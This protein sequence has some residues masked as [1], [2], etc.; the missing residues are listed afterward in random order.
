MH[1]GSQTCG[2]ANTADFSISN[3]LKAVKRTRITSVMDKQHFHRRGDGK[4]RIWESGNPLPLNPV[5][6]HPFRNFG[7][8]IL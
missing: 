5:L 3:P 7:T 4:D 8:N 6:P 2:L 1:K